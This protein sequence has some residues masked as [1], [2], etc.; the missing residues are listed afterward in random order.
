MRFLP[1]AL[2]AMALCCNRQQAAR[3]PGLSDGL[4]LADSTLWPPIGHVAVLEFTADW[5]GPCRASYPTLDAWTREYPG[6]HIV[7]ATTRLHRP[8]HPQQ[9]SAAVIAHL[10]DYFRNEYATDWP[11]FVANPHGEVE[12]AV[13]QA[14]H[15]DGVPHFVV[16]DGTGVV[17][18][19]FRGWPAARDPMDHLLASLRP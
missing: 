6:L 11:V 3:D 4:W 5:C 9:D 8:G 13:F 18:G 15:V 10:R 16:V 17:R 1:F 19:V 14:Y 7:L 2:M 12:G